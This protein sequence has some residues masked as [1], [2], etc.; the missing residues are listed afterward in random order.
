MPGPSAV[1]PPTEC[2]TDYRRVY[3]SQKRNAVAG[4]PAHIHA[5]LY[6]VA[7]TASSPLVS[8]LLAVYCVTTIRCFYMSMFYVDFCSPGFPLVG[9]PV[10]PSHTGLSWTVLSPYIMIRLISILIFSAGAY[11]FVPEIL[12]FV[13]FFDF[14][15]HF[16]TKLSNVSG[17]VLSDL[18]GLSLPFH[19]SYSYSVQVE[20]FSNG[21]AFRTHHCTSTMGIV[22]LGSVHQVESAWDRLAKALTGVAS[23]T[24]LKRIL[25]MPLYAASIPIKG[26][27]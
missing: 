11:W 16:L 1:Y 4:L 27:C 6:A 18:R 2:R 5:A 3:L 25:A 21:V 26:Y 22:L 24:P 20:L 19:R 12:F 13:T 7:I 23:P 17:F 9:F 10:S 8:T 14:F 15:W